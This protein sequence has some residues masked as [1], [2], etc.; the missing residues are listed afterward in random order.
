MPVAVG[1]PFCRSVVLSLDEDDF[2]D[3][4]SLSDD[5]EAYD[6]TSDKPSQK[7]CDARRRIEDILEEQQLVNWT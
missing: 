5:T 4:E 7:Q 3:D 6:N 2:E 1:R